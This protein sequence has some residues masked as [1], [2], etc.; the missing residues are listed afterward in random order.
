MSGQSF[1]IYGR[2]F[3]TINVVIL[4]TI[5]GTILQFFCTYLMTHSM[6]VADY[7]DFKVIRSFGEIGSILIILGGGRGALFFVPDWQAQNRSDLTWQYIRFYLSIAL[8][9][10]V[11]SV[12]ALTIV[13]SILKSFEVDMGIYGSYALLIAILGLPLAGASLLNIKILQIYGKVVPGLMTQW[14]LFPLAL[15]AI[16]IPYRFFEGHITVLVAVAAVF[17]VQCTIFASQFFLLHRQDIRPKKMQDCESS[18][19]QWLRFSIPVMMAGV[20]QQ[21][22]IRTDIFMLEILGDEADVGLFA[23]CSLGASILLVIKIA[24]SSTTTQ[25]MKQAYKDGNAG[26]LELMVK[27]NRRLLMFCLPLAAATILFGKDA[28]VSFGAEY[29][30]ADL[31][32]QILMAGYI[33]QTLFLLPLLW[34]EYTGKKNLAVSIM[35]FITILNIALNVA[36]IPLWQL[37]GA[38]VGTAISLTVGALLS[39]YFTWKHLKI[40]PW[41]IQS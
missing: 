38:A 10:A 15:A 8:C 26:M 3:D 27:G 4:T 13:Q 34:L 23:L 12:V 28:L 37:N 20:M 30:R 11:I 14:V 25:Y 6:T 18:W 5:V 40:I 19:P 41:S 7:G 16:L 32:L 29:A 21:L 2:K 39:A 36:L 1:S 33:I 35:I 9:I 22:V 31:A 17:I 24:V